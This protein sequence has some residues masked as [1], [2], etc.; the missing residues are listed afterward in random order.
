MIKKS[1]RHQ[2]IIGKYGEYLVCNWL[3]RSGFEVGIVDHTGIDMRYTTESL[4]ICP[5]STQLCRRIYPLH[6]KQEAINGLIDC[7][8]FYFRRH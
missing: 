3:S 1:T 5:N 4:L 8:N 2:H 6:Y 7:S